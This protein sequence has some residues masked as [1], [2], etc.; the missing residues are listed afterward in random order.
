MT[1]GAFGPV[2]RRLLLGGAC[3]AASAAAA[4]GDQPSGEY[5]TVKHR[6]GEAIELVL[7]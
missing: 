1:P 6:D 2:S 7:Y 3:L 4:P 5:R